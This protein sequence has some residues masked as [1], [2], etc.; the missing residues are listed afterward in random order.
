MI[1]NSYNFTKVE[2]LKYLRIFW[3]KFNIIHFHCNWHN[4]K[5]ELNRLVAEDKKEADKSRS[6]KCMGHVYQLFIRD[7]SNL[8]LD[9]GAFMDL[10]NHVSCQL[11][12]LL[13]FP[14]VAFLN[15]HYP[16]QEIL[17]R[18]ITRL[19]VEKQNSWLIIQ[20]LEIIYLNN[21]CSLVL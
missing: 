16:S 4:T 19:D 3:G 14:L 15:N 7:W 9:P 1:P 13:V 17:R 11:I 12:H 5:V 20:V 8:V 10:G 6:F 2:K 21:M 18:I